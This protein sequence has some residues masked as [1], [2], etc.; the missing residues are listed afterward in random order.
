MCS[1]SVINVRGL[2]ARRGARRPSRRLTKLGAELSA[3]KELALKVAAARASEAERR[4]EHVRT[5]AE[6]RQAQV[7]ERERR[8]ERERADLHLI[9]SD[10]V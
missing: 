5:E 6:R 1:A 3:A 9:A 8:L 10:C 4:V 7:L 2:C